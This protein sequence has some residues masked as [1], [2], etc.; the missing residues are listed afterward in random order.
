MKEYIGREIGG[1]QL[2]EQIGA[3]G[4]AKVYKAYQSGL[5]RMVA[6]KILP[7]TYAEDENYLKRFD[8]EARLIASLEHAHI[9]PVF[10]FGEEDKTAF[11]AMRYLQAGNLKNILENSPESLLPLKDVVKIIQ[12]IASALDYAHEQGIV[13]RDV[14]PSNVLIDSDGDAFLTDFGI[15]KILDQTTQLTTTGAV[16]GTPTYMSPEQG[17]GKSIDH[18]SDIYSLGVLAYQIV[19]GQAPYEAETPVAVLLAHVNEEVPHVWDVAPNIPKEIG[20]VIEKALAKDPEDRFESAGKFA[21]ALVAAA[22]DL[23]EQSAGNLTRLGSQVAGERSS[24]TVTPSDR[25]LVRRLKRQHRMRKLRP[26]LIGLVALMVIGIPFIVGN[27]QSTQALQRE[28]TLQAAQSATLDQTQA[29]LLVEQVTATAEVI[30]NMTETQA[31]HEV[32]LT[33]TATALTPEP[34]ATFTATPIP[35]VEVVGNLVNMREGPS[36]KFG[37]M[38]TLIERDRA[39]L[40]G[41]NETGSWLKIKFGGQS[42]WIPASAELTLDIDKDRVAV[43]E[44][45]PTPTSIPFFSV[46]VANTTNKIIFIR[47][48]GAGLG[49]EGDIRPG[50]QKTFYVQYANYQIS[51]N[52]NDNSINSGKGCLQF[53]LIDRDIFWQPTKANICTSFP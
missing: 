39:E 43:V 36:T 7:D 5:D 3:G 1:Y 44:S 27:I 17:A 16:L 31:Q 50:E 52:F 32:N 11:L 20:L 12:Q 51:V 19:T 41:K 25:R 2:L 28:A 24:E 45:P 10:D 15:A 33:H 14:K 29:V 23:I 53:R 38:D 48:G 6:V 47:F 30:L 21:N 37:I 4:M 22:G 26:V 18:R 49:V 9:L 46:T 35:M 13:H 34:T 42:G 40:L 8:Q